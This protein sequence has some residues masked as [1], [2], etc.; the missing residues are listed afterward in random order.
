MTN[1]KIPQLPTKNTNI[2]TGDYLIIED[3]DT[4]TTMKYNAALL[5]KDPKIRVVNPNDQTGSRPFFEASILEFENVTSVT[6]PAVSIGGTPKIVVD[7]GTPSSTE[8]VVKVSNNDTTAGFLLSKLTAGSNIT[9]TETS[10]G[11]NETITIQSTY[12]NPY[13]KI[14]SN[15]G[16]ANFANAVGTDSIALGFS[17]NCSTSE[18]N[19]IAIGKTATAQ[20]INSISIGTNSN[21]ARGTNNINIGINSFSEGDNSIAIGQTARAEEN[22]S[23][24]LG[25]GTNNTDNTFQYL[26]NTLANA[27]GLYTSFTSPTNY[28]PTDTDNITSHL[29]AIDT[30]LA[31]TGGASGTPS[32]L[33]TKGDLYTYSTTEARLPIGTD[34]QIL[35]ADSSTTTGLSWI[36][37]PSG[38]TANSGPDSLVFGT[39]KTASFSIATTDHNT[40]IPVEDTLTIT[41]PNLTTNTEVNI[42][43]DV[44]NK[45]ITYAPG[46]GAAIKAPSLTQ[47]VIHTTVNCRFNSATSTWLLRGGLS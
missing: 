8:G 15:G 5:T 33:T 30:V 3:S 12:S 7:V 11:G 29:Q 42:D 31:N 27:Q 24:Q 39:A 28:T 14:N 41:L 16:T 19:K 6:Q 46:S 22:N 25:T 18:I 2:V 32:P 45:V 40:N 10:D 23:I 47:S 20:T 9:L 34:G 1:K 44:S 4:S 26:T 43:L 35:S 21:N 36:D 38:G 17:A 13:L 37:A